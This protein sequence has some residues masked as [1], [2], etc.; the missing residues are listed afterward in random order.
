MNTM[1]QK[2]RKIKTSNATI[3]GKLFR[4]DNAA[5]LVKSLGFDETREEDGSVSF[6]LKDS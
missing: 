1:E 4:L 2:F 6:E 5:A 3:K